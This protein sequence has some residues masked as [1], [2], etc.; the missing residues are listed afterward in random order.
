MK[1]K[2]LLHIPHNST[3]LPKKFFKQQI[4]IDKEELRLF[5]LTM[6]D[7]YTK[8]LFSSYNKKIV[9]PY[10]RI[11]CDV[12]KFVDDKEEM[13]SK[14]GMGVLYT[15]T[16]LGKDFIHFGDDYK[17]DIIN[18]YYNVFHK[19]LD[20]ASIK[21]TKSSNLILVDCHSFSSSTTAIFGES[22]SPDICLGINDIYFSQTLLDFVKSYFQNLGYTVSVNSP[23]SGAMIPDAFINKKVDGFYSIMIEINKS[24]Y[25]ENFNKNHHFKTLRK[26]IKGLLKLLKDIKL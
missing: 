9:A 11:F 19:K 13:M 10:S 4:L 23:Y 3:R 1:N 5:N 16:N 18:S 24:L 17:E 21:A 22:A 14:F 26:E 15:K 12:E 6:T 20:K 7:L 25:L 8:D 2:I